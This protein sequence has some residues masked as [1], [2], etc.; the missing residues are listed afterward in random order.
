MPERAD[1]TVD[2]EE[3]AHLSLESGRIQKALVALP[4]EQQQAIQ[5]AYFDGLSSSEIAQQLEVPLGTVKGRLRIGLQKMR[6]LLD[7]GNLRE[8]SHDPR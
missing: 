4:L 1:E 6:A 5:L 2:V 3:Q 7:R 8:A